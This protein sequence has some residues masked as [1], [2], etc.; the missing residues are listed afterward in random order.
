[1]AGRIFSVHPRVNLLR[2]IARD[3]LE[4]GHIS[5]PRTVVVF[6]HRRPIL[7]FEYYLSQMVDGPI[8]LPKL[9]AFEDWVSELYAEVKDD[10]EPSLSEMDQAYIAYLSSKEVLGAEGRDV[11]LEGFFLWAMRIV[12][13]FKDFDLELKVPKDLIYPP[14]GE[15]GDEE[16][17]I[18]ERLG[19]IYEGFSRIL[20]KRH[21][22]TYA[23]KLRFLA[24]LSPKRSL[25]PDGRPVYIVGF[26]AL[27]EA[28]NRLFKSLYLDGTYIYWHADPD[29]LPE[30]YVRWKDSWGVDIEP[31][32]P[33]RDF[34]SEILLFEGYDLHSELEELYSR[35]K[36]RA[37]CDRPD[38]TSIVLLSTGSLIPTIFHIPGGFPVNVTMGYPFN[39]TSIYMFLESIFNLVMGRD[40]RGYYLKDLLG[41][42]KGPFFDGLKGLEERLVDHGAPFV[43]VDEVLELSEDKAEYVGAIFKEVVFPFE[44]MRTPRDLAKALDGAIRFVETQRSFGPYEDAFSRVLR[45]NL[46]YPLEHSLLSDETMEK[47]GLLRLFKDLASSLRVPFSGEPLRGLQVM[48]LL[49]TRLLNFDEVF[50]LDANEGV[51]PSVEEVNPLAPQ[52]LRKALG[53]PDRY[54]EEVISRYHF[55]RL[56]Q[57]SKKAHI[58]WQ[59]Q[60]VSGD[61]GLEGRKVRS[62]F[63][64]R[65]IWDME[66]DKKG[67]VLEDGR[68][69][70]RASLVI[71]P[72]SLVPPGYLTKGESD[73]EV[74]KRFLGRISPTLLESYVLCPLRFYYSRVLGLKRKE[75]QGDVAFD[76]LGEAVHKALKDFYAEI[77]CGGCGKVVRSSLKPERLMALFEDAIKDMDFCRV[78][79]EEKRFMLKKTALFRFKRF[80]L[81]QPEETEVLCLERGF[82][83]PFHVA[84]LGDVVL[85]G[86][87]DRVDLRGG[88]YVVL[89][90]K[91][92]RVDELRFSRASKLSD[93]PCEYDLEGLSFVLKNLPGF[94]LPF[95]MYLFCLNMVEKVP[96]IWG[97]VVS[98]YVMLGKDGSERYFPGEIPKEGF[99]RWLSETFP[100]VLEYV[101]CHMIQSSHWFPAP[102]RR[103]CRYCQYRGFCRYS[104]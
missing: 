51:M 9:F 88:V 104:V 35:L 85:E 18:L 27:T 98:A 94:Q 70:K 29:D 22:T 1:M 68:L 5:D 71:P 14:E 57:S 4:R 28:E 80:I 55:E 38:A 10:P 13:L 101:I 33:D 41:F 69:F 30:L 81:L 84:G 11:S 21:L 12:E 53:L 24:E 58:F 92:G 74:L 52:R 17:R 31:V 64:E 62:R 8:L 23:R 67:F 46:L 65:I 79:S 56:I 49:E 89:D 103:A 93:I 60:M 50:I 26:Y 75:V 78:L 32:F 44:S 42:I 2:H 73:L 87:I 47:G 25:Y 7:F 96:D 36:E 43:T 102:D 15:I 63:V 6:P 90:Y 72:E 59:F 16:A 97:R 34:S 19:R 77:L 83:A 86:R 40:E 39:L 3:M 20:E 100:R 82:E 99:G 95:Y 76:Q 61:S 66:K 54:R 48:G 45:E 37:A 91:T